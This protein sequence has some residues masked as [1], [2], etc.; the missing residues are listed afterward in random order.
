[1]D[2]ENAKSRGYPEF[3][4]LGLCHPPDR[5]TVYFL[6]LSDSHTFIAMLK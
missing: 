5:S 2:S 1:M 3:R 4:V 6:P